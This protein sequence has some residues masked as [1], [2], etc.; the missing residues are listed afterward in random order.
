MNEEYAQQAPDM[1][2]LR[3][4]EEK[5]RLLKDRIIL[6]GKSLIEEREKSFNEMQELKKSAFVL[7]EEQLRMK[8]II[9]RIAEQLNATARKE[10][11]MI[12]QR[13]LDMIRKT[14]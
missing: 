13:Q 1:A 11:L 9:Q 3:D 8:E 12:L 6:I 5:Q 4:I 14:G 2:R 10:E 7:K